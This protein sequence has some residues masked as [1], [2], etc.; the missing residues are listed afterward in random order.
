MFTDRRRLVLLNRGIKTRRHRSCKPVKRM[1]SPTRRRRRQNCWYRPELL[2]MRPGKHGAALKTCRIALEYAGPVKS[3]VSGA[4][5]GR[6]WRTGSIRRT[7][8]AEG[9]SM[10]AW[11]PR[12]RADARRDYVPVDCSMGG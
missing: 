12:Y 11:P 6:R 10:K 4:G 9:H 7:C 2:V 5:Y 1:A 8:C 3:E